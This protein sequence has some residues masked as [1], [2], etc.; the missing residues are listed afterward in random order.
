MLYIANV[1][2]HNELG[3][4]LYSIH[5]TSLYSYILI[6]QLT[7]ILSHMASYMVGIIYIYIYICIYTVKNG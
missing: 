6:A 3:Y 2:T 1:T 4:R 5:V 7:C